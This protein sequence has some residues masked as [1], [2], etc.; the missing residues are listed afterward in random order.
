VQIHHEQIGWLVISEKFMRQILLVFVVSL[1]LSAS[2]FGEYEVAGSSFKAVFPCKPV[3]SRGA[4]SM[5]YSCSIN[6]V[7]DPLGAENELL[8]PRIGGAPPQ[9]TTKIDYKLV[10][11]ANRT[12]ELPTEE[13][14]IKSLRSQHS[15]KTILDTTATSGK[16]DTGETSAEIEYVDAL[17]QRPSI[18]HHTVLRVFITRTTIYKAYA[19]VL[20]RSGHY[21]PLS[22]VGP[23]RVRNYPI[24]E[25]LSQRE[26]APSSASGSGNG[27]QARDLSRNR[28]PEVVTDTDGLG[29][30]VFANGS[31]F[32]TTLYELKVIGELRTANKLPYYILSGRGC[33]QCGANTSLYIHS[34]SD[35][36]M[37]N[38]R[39]QTHFSYPGKETNY[40]DG[41]LL[42][43]SRAFFG[44]CAAGHQN[45]VIW[46]QKSIDDNR[47]WHSRVFVA[48]VNADRLS[49]G[50][51]SD[52]VPNLSEA[53]AA[54][55]AGGCREI[56]G[57]NRTSEP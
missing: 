21:D 49:D 12:Q 29:T 18:F 44:D 56:P 39:E 40:M 13:A 16:T 33:H 46:F 32:T 4:G 3:V 6:S 35:G 42:F 57:I 38:E 45:A 48:Q 27:G 17:S 34:P 54:V 28:I 41:Q 19:T 10:V 11:S 53:E 31:K 2:A 36:S 20:H 7:E 5:I 55:K 24:V 23:G 47:K 26:T 51:L 30:L 8:Y 52:A 43:E 22:F 25:R 14:L 15:S 9:A 50:V 37:R 1:V